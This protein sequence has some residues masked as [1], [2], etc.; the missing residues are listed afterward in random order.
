M[1]EDTDRSLQSHLPPPHPHSLFLFLITTII[2]NIDKLI[3]FLHFFT[4]SVG[5]SFKSVTWSIFGTYL[6][7]FGVFQTIQLLN[8]QKMSL[9][10][11]QH[12]SLVLQNLDISL[13][14]RFHLSS[15]C[16]L[17][18]F[19]TSN[20]F[21]LSPPRPLLLLHLLCTTFC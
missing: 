5:E 15:R 3:Y 14:Y 16:I 17:F 18:Q 20:V 7:V 6:F 12:F 13:L 2:I 19:P 9:A 4:D 10:S 8:Y 11:L 21:N 1:L